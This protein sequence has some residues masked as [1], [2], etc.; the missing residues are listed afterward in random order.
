MLVLSRKLDEAIVIGDEIIVKVLNVRGGQ[1]RLGI[2]A[3]SDLSVHREEVYERIHGHS[4]R[5]L[6]EHQE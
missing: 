5:P 6:E 4:P 1:I 3:P 2:T